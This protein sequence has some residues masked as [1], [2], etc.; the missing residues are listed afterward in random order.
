MDEFRPQ[1]AERVGWD[2][3]ECLSV[4]GQ[5]SEA[6]AHTQG[7]PP[8]RLADLAG[9]IE[10]QVIPRLMLVHTPPAVP[11]RRRAFGAKPVEELAALVLECDAGAALAYVAALR[12]RGAPLESIYL[13]LLTPVA[14]HLGKLW[15]ADLCNFTEVTIG[16]CCLQQ[17]LN[18]LS[19]ERHAERQAPQRGRRALL[20]PVPGEQHTF[21]LNMVAE[22]LR[23]AG[24]DVRV[25][26]GDSKQQLV[27]LVRAEWF[28]IIGFSVS[29]EAYLD[30]L[31]SAVRAIRRASLN[32]GIGVMVGG[33]VFV[34]HPELAALVGAD[35]TAT[36]ARQ[37]CLHADELYTL[38]VGRAA[39]QTQGET[40]FGG[41]ALS[42]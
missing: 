29:C 5:L 38:A 26:T 18:G 7:F 16:L 15:E 9:M 6:S 1:E 40:G 41:A 36:D 11:G 3:G 32:R 21:G 8:D 28:A 13:E 23:R 34:E 19:A 33:R 20:A 42:T 37:T 24:W 30:V 39:W 14:R 25:D 4:D 2:G 12:D 27:A 17:V 35:A 31:A 22:F 10:A